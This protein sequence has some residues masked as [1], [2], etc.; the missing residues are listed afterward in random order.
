[1]N[2]VIQTQTDFGEG[3]IVNEES[4][5][6]YSEGLALHGRLGYLESSKP[7][8]VNVLLCSP[9]PFMCG[10]MENNVIRSI[11]RT[12]SQNGFTSFCFNYRGVG[13]SQTDRDLQEDQHLYWR[14]ATCKDYEK[15]ISIDCHA[16]LNFLLKKSNP[17]SKIILLGYAFG[18]RPTLQLATNNRISECILIAPELNHSPTFLSLESIQKEV[19]IFFASNDT[20]CNRKMVKNLHVQ[21]P[22]S[23]FLAYEISQADHFFIGKENDLANQI[24]FHLTNKLAESK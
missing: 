11:Y 3:K 17:S 12:L 13:H 20:T 24:L 6:F 22:N 23:T 4:I 19:A 15:K 21:I 16:A 10:D 5:I 2:N 14:Y 18:C 9:H 8:L 7:S 1:M